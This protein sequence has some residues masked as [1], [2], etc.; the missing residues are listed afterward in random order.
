LLLDEPTNH[1]DLDVREALAEALAEFPGALV[2][3]SH[4]R[5]L[6]GMVCDSFWRVADGAVERFDGDLDDYAR[7]LRSRRSDAGNG[8]GARPPAQD[9]ARDRRRA[10]AEQRERERPLRQRM[11]AIEKR[12]AAIDGEAAQVAEA[13]ADPALYERGDGAEI[14]RLGQQQARLAAEREALEHEWLELGEQ[15]SA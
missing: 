6:I 2:L 1:L 14:A 9:S 15:L 3:V 8:A 10:A 4:D 12:L 13:L 11:Q 5:H 7:W